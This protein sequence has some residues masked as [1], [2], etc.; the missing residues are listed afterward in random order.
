[1]DVCAVASGCTSV[2]MFALTSDGRVFG[3][4]RNEKG[5]LGLGH[6]RDR[7]CPT[8]ITDMDDKKVVAAA[9]GRNHSLLLTGQKACFPGVVTVFFFFLF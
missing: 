4:G 6:A 8:Q 9:T 5:Q 1:M 3:W 7:K 2:H